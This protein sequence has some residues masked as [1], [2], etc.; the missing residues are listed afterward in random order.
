MSWKRYEIKNDYYKGL[1]LVDNVT[2]EIIEEMNGKGGCYNACRLLNNL[3]E[4]K[5]ELEEKNKELEEQ[6]Q[7]FEEEQCIYKYMSIIGT[8]AIDEINSDKN[9]E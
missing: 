6:I 3:E 2:N 9:G 1:I 7:K 5:K 4:K 8:Y